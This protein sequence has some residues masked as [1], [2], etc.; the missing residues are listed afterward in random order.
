MKNLRILHFFGL[1]VSILLTSN[2][3]AFATGGTMSGSGTAVSPYLVTDYAD[4]KAIGTGSYTL[5]AVYRLA[6]DINAFESISENGGAGFIPIGNEA[7]HFTGTFHGAGHVI[8]NLYIQRPTANYIGLF[9][10]ISISTI[11]S[12]GINASIKGNYFVGSIVGSNYGKVSNCYAYGT[13]LGVSIVGGIVGENNDTVINCYSSNICHATGIIHEGSTVGGIAGRNSFASISHCHSTGIV[14][15]D[16]SEVGGVVGRNNNSTLSYCYATGAITGGSEVGGIVGINQEGTISSCYASGSVKGN[17]Q[18][19]GGIIGSNGAGYK[20][21]GTVLNCYAT[22]DVT[23]G[24]DVGGIA[25]DNNDIISNCYATGKVTGSY[26][27]GV[28]GNNYESTITHCY[29]NI[30]TTGLISGHADAGSLFTGSGLSSEKMQKASSFSGWDFNT[31]WL[32]RTDSTYPGLRGMNNAPFALPDS[33][34]SNR[35]FDLHRLFLND[36]DIETGQKNLH[37]Q[38]VHISEG[39]TDGA[40]TFTFPDNAINGTVDTIIYRIWKNFVP[41]ILWGNTAKAIITLDET[42]T[43]VSSLPK[44]SISQIQ[45]YPNPFTSATTIKY[46]VTE[47]GY[48]SLKIFDVIGTEVASLAN[49]RK[50]AGEY[51]IE[52]NAT[53]FGNGIYFCKLQNGNFSEAK[54][55]MLQK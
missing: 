16:I 24:I 3:L 50:P 36:F 54:K 35:T 1:V 55:M 23:G 29:W 43:S 33:L 25:G 48:V 28:A 5:S 37:V 38:I 51:S 15:G 21:P 20:G 6:S 44:Q 52:W 2:T 39:R 49:E 42:F 8:K 14:T 18:S 27:G 47:P 7:T 17:S 46:K 12:L 30:M 32:I 53:G 9:G 41:D 19:I 11:D 10:Y 34:I 40:N 22:G 13:V 4:L 26:I 45:N 31:V